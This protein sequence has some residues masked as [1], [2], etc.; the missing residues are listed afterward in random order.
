MAGKTFNVDITLSDEEIASVCDQIE[1][2]A[3]SDVQKVR[4]A[5]IKL[6]QGLAQGG[7][8]LWPI[9]VQKI[10][11]STGV[12]LGTGDDLLPYLSAATGL[13]NGLYT[14]KA[15]I[16]PIYHQRME[17]ISQI[18]GWSVQQMID[19][20]ILA[21]LE[22][23]W[24]ESIPDQ[25]DRILMTAESRKELQELL[26]QKFDSGTELAELIKQFLGVGVPLLEEPEAVK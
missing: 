26:G 22:N 25:P 19:E 6:V 2:D 23:N 7:L 17:E 9:E 14:Y 13:E 11:E 3:V 1:A 24:Y 5:A 21:C 15:Q 16:D 10:E 12:S 18:R 20:M 8:M 4:I